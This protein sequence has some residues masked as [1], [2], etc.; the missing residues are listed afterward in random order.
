MLLAEQLSG[1]VGKIAPGLG[2]GRTLPGIGLLPY[3]RLVH[4]RFMKRYCEDIVPYL[5][6]TGF[7]SSQAVDRHLQFAISPLYFFP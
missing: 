5:Y 4:Y 1:A 3:Q 2:A 6:L 7:L